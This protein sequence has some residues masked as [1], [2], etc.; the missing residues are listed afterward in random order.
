MTQKYKEIIYVCCLTGFITITFA[1]GRYIFAMITPDIVS[2]LGLDYEFIGR[3]NALHQCAYLLFSLLGGLICQYISIRFIISSSVILCSLS[4][5]TLAFVYNP[6]ILLVLVTLQGVFAA[7]SWIPMVEFVSENIQEKNRGKSL[8]IIS[9]GTSYGLILNGML[10]P[11]ILTDYSWQKVWL[12]FGIISLILGIIGTYW[13]YKLQSDKERTVDSSSQLRVVDEPPLQYN[14]NTKGYRKHYI[15]LILLLVLSGLYLIPYQSYIVPLMKED[16]GLSEQIAG[17]SWTLFGVIGIGSG[18]VAGILADKFSAK[19]AMIITYSISVISIGTIVIFHN[20]AAV[21]FS[22]AIFGLT[23]N[24]IFGLHPTY[25]SRILPPEKTAKFFG[26][27]NLS[28]GLGSMIGNY[29]G[30]YIK[31]TT[32]TFT[33]SYQFMLVV[34]LLA[35]LICFY[36]KSDSKA[37]SKKEFQ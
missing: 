27:L 5:I 35:V 1:F 37:D 9:S 10:I 13:I 12:V 19:K 20:T 30:G 14:S 23:Y 6:W 16:F 25:V 2:S 33:L 29:L 31:I 24:G 17:I 34:S 7:T 26:V 21:I 15:L 32:G 18:L 4:L 22:C 36:I 8:G 3:I 11:P 28:L